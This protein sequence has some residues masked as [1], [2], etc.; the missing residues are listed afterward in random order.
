ME[1]DAGPQPS[2]PDGP[3]AD[4]AGQAAWPPASPVRNCP[5]QGRTV[6]AAG[7]PAVQVCPRAYEMA[8]VSEGLAITLHRRRWRRRYGICK[9]YW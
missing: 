6:H 4:A 8:A 1:P 7:P 5:T 3:A 2:P 9:F